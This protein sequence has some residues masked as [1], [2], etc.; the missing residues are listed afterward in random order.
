MRTIKTEIIKGH[1]FDIKYVR[2]YDEYQVIHKGY[3]DHTYYTADKA[4]AI[5]TIK[6]MVEGIESPEPEFEI[7]SCPWCG[8]H[9]DGALCKCGATRQY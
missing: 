2:Q 6:D 7:V 9:T 4:D 1:R 5:A 3:S 8:Q